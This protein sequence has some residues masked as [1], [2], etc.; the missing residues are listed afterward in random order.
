MLVLP[1]TCSMPQVE[2]NPA[3]RAFA[4]K[5]KS[6]MGRALDGV[7]HAVNTHHRA[8]AVILAYA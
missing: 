4:T 3:F 5:M 6:R 1:L 7:C 8:A 2:M